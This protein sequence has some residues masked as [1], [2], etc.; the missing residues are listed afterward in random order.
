MIF[1]DTDWEGDYMGCNLSKVILNSKQFNQMLGLT[2][3][4]CIYG[5]MN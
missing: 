5:L 4:L 3:D 1:S 2:T